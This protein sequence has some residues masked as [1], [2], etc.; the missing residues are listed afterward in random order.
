MK[1]ARRPLLILAAALVA[2]PAMAQSTPS[3]GKVA[4]RGYDA[5]AYFTLGRPEQGNPSI[6]HQWDGRRY[7]FANE[8]H[9]ELFV[10]D[11][12]KYAPQF[13]GLCSAG[14]SAGMKIEADPKN[15]I[16]SDGRLFLFAGVAGPERAR[17]DPT[18]LRRA[19]A[20]WAKQH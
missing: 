13:A 9:R 18:L 2:S 11:P 15:W 17:N 20:N 12:D 4:I 7:L 16:I 8:I 3:D 19:D 5:V 1:F 6:S 14:M 10:R